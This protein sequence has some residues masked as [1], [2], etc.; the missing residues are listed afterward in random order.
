M[1]VNIKVIV[2]Y[3]DFPG[4]SV[5]KDSVLPRQGAQVQSLVRELDPAWHNYEIPGAA[6][7]TW[8][9]QN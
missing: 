2:V 3:R 9:S 7:T 6:T 4:G 5:A 1:A 8:C